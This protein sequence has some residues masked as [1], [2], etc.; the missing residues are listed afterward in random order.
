MTK[1]IIF[2]RLNCNHKIINTKQQIIVNMFYKKCGFKNSK[3][4][5][6]LYEWFIN[7]DTY[8]LWGKNIGHFHLVNKFDLNKI[9]NLKI[10]KNKTIYGTFL[11]VRMN[12]SNYIDIDENILFKN[13]NENINN[14]CNSNDDVK[15]NSYS[16]S[17]NDLI[18]DSNNL[19]GDENIY[20]SSE[21]HEEEYSEFSDIN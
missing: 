14:V 19:S 13:N 12:N 2:N 4:F 6:I 10:D 15:V 16:N 8:Q 20:S 7:N 11:I 9:I 5:T 1:I 17:N 3:N 18:L 21:L